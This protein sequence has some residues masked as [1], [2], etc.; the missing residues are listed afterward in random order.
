MPTLL[1]QDGFRFFFYSKENGEPPHI[2]VEK[3][4][5]EGQAK[6]WLETLTLSKCKNIADHDITKIRKIVKDNQ[7]T[8]IEAW[9]EHF[10][11]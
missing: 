7:Q 2:H 4:I 3:R 6:F 1:K 8:F 10:G 11:N 5:G 9:Y